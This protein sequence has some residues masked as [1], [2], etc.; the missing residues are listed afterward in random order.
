LFCILNL[1]AFLS[2]NPAPRTARRSPARP[3]CIP[4]R[5]SSRAWPLARP[6]V[7]GPSQV[8]R[9]SQGWHPGGGETEAKNQERPVLS[10]PYHRRQNDLDAKSIFAISSAQEIPRRSNLHL[11]KCSSRFWDEAL[12][13][14]DMVQRPSVHLHFYRF[15][16]WQLWR[17]RKKPAFSRARAASA[18][19]TL[20]SLSVIRRLPE[21]SS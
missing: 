7:C 8:G 16:G 21:M 4:V 1:A 15:C 9:G 19:L 18:A 3:A 2:S 10:Y 14:N 20:G 6:C 11:S 5:S 17:A 12:F 13:Q